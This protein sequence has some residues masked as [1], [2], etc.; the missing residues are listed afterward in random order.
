MRRALVVLAVVVVVPLVVV[1]TVV[2]SAFLGRSP[3][4]DA[5]DIA[6]G[7]R[8]LKDGMVAVFVLDAGGGNARYW[9]VDR[10]SSGGSA[11][12]WDVDSGGGGGGV[13][14]F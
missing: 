13:V 2:G 14:L 7:V 9:D 8:L 4:P 12:Y 1:L 10:G 11:T 5:A 3:L 6:D